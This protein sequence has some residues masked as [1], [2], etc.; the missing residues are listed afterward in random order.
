MT[1]KRTPDRPPPSPGAPPCS[2]LALVLL[3]VGPAAFTDDTQLLRFDTAK[4]Y[5][6]IVLDT[7][8][9]MGLDFDTSADQWTPGGADGPGSRLYQAKQALYNVFEDVSDV[10]FGFAS[11]NQDQVRAWSKHWIYY[12]NDALPDGWALP[13]PATET[14]GP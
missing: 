14:T 7:S 8:A 3:V 9:S 4:P 11:F 2:A 1:P 13:F 10:H 5:V 12:H 6:F